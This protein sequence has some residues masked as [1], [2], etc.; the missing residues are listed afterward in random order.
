MST[1][2]LAIE[3]SCDDTAL[4]IIS[5]SSEGV[6]C[7]AQ[8]VSSQTDLHAQWGGVVP[9]LA[10]REH[11][12]NI[13][14]LLKYVLNESGFMPEDIDLIA[15]TQGPGLIPAL[16]IGTSVAKTLS[17]L[18]EK[19]LIGIHHVEGHIYANFTGEI[20]NPSFIF[21]AL[22]LVVSGGHTQ[23]VLMRDHFNYEII[24]QTLDDAAGEAFDKVARILNIGYPGGPAISKYSEMYTPY[25]KE[26][27]SRKIKFPRPMLNKDNFDFSFSG[28]KTAVLYETKKHPELL[29]DEK[30]V[31][32]VCHEFQQAVVDVLVQK[33]INAAEKYEAKTILLAGGVSANKELRSQLGTAIKKDLNY[34]SNRSYPSYITPD[35]SLTGDNATMIGAA[36]AFRWQHMNDTEKEAAKNSWQTLVPDANLKL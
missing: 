3:T 22:C 8:I 25:T 12:K 26:T 13:F 32:E 7:L 18:W 10:A 24:G 6:S 2:I 21:P 28:L 1:K 15:I 29:G 14:P 36:A 35:L 9:N 30:Y 33:T 5:A 20:K 11:Q 4:S 34:L 31:V 27:A 23:L 19:P 17:Y 16:L